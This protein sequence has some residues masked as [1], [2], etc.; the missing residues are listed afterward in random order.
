MNQQETWDAPHWDQPVEI[1]PEERHRMIAVAA[2]F[3]AER[4]DFAPGRELDDWC[5]AA[6]DI[7]RMLAN[8]YQG[9]VTRRDYERTGLR[10]ALRL[11]VK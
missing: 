4:R 6:V 7:D 11:W 10:N 1:S 9:G 3:R 5:E 2:Y 8:M